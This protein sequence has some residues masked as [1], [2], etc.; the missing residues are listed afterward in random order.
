MSEHRPG[1]R[2]GDDSGGSDTG[3]NVHQH[4]QQR[5]PPMAEHVHMDESSDLR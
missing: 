2:P 5:H 3:G 1:R 4:G